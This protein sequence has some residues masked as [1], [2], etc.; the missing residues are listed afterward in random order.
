MASR[1]SRI[2]FHERVSPG[3]APSDGSSKTIR[4][5]DPG[6][7]ARVRLSSS[8][9][10]SD[11]GVARAGAV[12]RRPDRAGLL[13]RPGI[14]APE[15]LVPGNHRDAAACEAGV[16]R[17][18]PALADEHQRQRRR[19]R[20]AGGEVRRGPGR[21]SCSSARVMYRLRSF[22]RHRS[23]LPPKALT[24]KQNPTLWVFFRCRLTMSRTVFLLIPMS[25][26]IQR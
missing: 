9:S 21:M 22:F 3:P 14:A 1:P 17:R 10:P 26:A 4:R 15:P 13:L 8:S 23:G 18:A 11:A 20:L 2:S 24:Q 25:R 7:A 16:Q 12:E 19:G 5:P 6:K